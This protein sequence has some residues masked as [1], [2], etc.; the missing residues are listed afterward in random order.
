MSIQFFNNRKVPS[1][2]SRLGP[3]SLIFLCESDFRG[4]GRAVTR[5]W[6][7]AMARPHSDKSSSDPTAGTD[8]SDH[9]SLTTLTVASVSSWSPA[10]LTLEGFSVS[11]LLFL[12]R[13]PLPSPFPTHTHYPWFSWPFF[14]ISLQML[15][16][17]LYL[18]RKSLT[19]NPKPI[20]FP[21]KSGHKTTIQQ[22]HHSW[23]YI[24]HPVCLF[25]PQTSVH[26]HSLTQQR[27]WFQ[28]GPLIS[29]LRVLSRVPSTLS[30][31]STGTGEEE[32][33][34]PAGSPSPCCVWA[35][36]PQCPVPVCS[37]PEPGVKSVTGHLHW[38][39]TTG[40]DLILC[41]SSLT[42][43][44]LLIPSVSTELTG[45]ATQGMTFQEP[46]RTWKPELRAPWIP[47]NIKMIYIAS[48]K[49]HCLA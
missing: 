7:G 41:S 44:W 20:H 26:I 2:C 42:S 43:Q 34:Y 9:S 17:S 33:P 25:Q 32:I 13:V 22:G 48:V 39:H 23:H 6:P 37:H 8:R 10:A 16:L 29:V 47:S 46:E 11:L 21:P 49:H 40:T 15:P 45:T 35:A 38:I 36:P 14:L 4:R 5:L 1:T 12:S 18:F 27:F 28:A 19:K 31:C 30:S 3:L 24:S